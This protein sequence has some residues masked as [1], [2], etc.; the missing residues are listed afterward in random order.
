MLQILM[1]EYAAADTILSPSNLNTKAAR[2]NAWTRPL[3]APSGQGL[4]IQLTPNFN[5]VAFT[6]AK[7]QNLPGE[8]LIP[9]FPR[10]VKA[11][12]SINSRFCIVRNP[13]KMSKD[14]LNASK[15]TTTNF[16]LSPSDPQ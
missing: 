2:R 10:H 3:D 8:L 11:I 7:L 12:D 5:T 9:I 1:A 16:A 13:P 4:V 15:H 6:G 14:A